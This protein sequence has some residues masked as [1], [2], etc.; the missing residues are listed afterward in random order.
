MIEDVNAP[1]VMRSDSSTPLVSIASDVYDARP[2]PVVLVAMDLWTKRL[3]HEERQA[4][5]DELARLQ[6]ELAAMAP[7]AEAIARVAAR[8]E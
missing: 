4:I 5:I 3:S 8:H 2:R 1:V 7:Y 6:G